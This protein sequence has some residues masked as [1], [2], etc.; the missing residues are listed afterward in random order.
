MERLTEKKSDWNGHYMKCADQ[1]RCDGKCGDCPELDRIVHRLAYYEDLEEQGRLVVLP[2]KV[3]DTFF[4]V[5]EFVN[6]DE[7]PEMYEDKVRY[8][9][10]QK[11]RETGELVFCIEGI[12]FRYDDFGKTV[13]L[14][15]EEAEAALKKE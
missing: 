4:D 8:I 6:G 13:F 12:D 5:S 15:R 9:E 2:C 10:L 14:T 7:Y 3:G 11:D 1:E